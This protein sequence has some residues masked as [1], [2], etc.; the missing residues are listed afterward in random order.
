[1]GSWLCGLYRCLSG[2][3]ALN[4]VLEGL[5]QDAG[6]WAG[7]VGYMAHNRAGL[8]SSRLQSSGRDRNFSVR[9]ARGARL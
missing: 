6:G 2:A 8:L 7:R 4:R 5:S 1:M 9:L 3:S